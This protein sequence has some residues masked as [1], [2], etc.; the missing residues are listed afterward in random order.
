[1]ER[2]QHLQRVTILATSKA[3]TLAMGLVRFLSNTGDLVRIHSDR[4]TYEA[5]KVTLAVPQRPGGWD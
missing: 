4:E 2:G 5:R 3:T 1:M